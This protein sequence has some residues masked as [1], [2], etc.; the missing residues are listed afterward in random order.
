MSGFIFFQS[1]TNID[2]NRVIR[3]CEL[4]GRLSRKR[5]F[6]FCCF[7][8][9]IVFFFLKGEPRLVNVSSQCTGWVVAWRVTHAGR[10]RDWAQLCEHGQAEN[11]PVFYHRQSHR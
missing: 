6:A 7:F 4:P 9:L 1:G 5:T 3:K 8:F 10:R 2:R 11:P